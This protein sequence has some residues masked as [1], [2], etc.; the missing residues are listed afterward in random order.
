[1]ALMMSHHHAA[2]RQWPIVRSWEVKWK[3]TS[4]AAQQDAATAAAAAACSCQAPPHVAGHVFFP[5]TFQAVGGS[6]VGMGA[7][8]PSA[9]PASYAYGLL[10]VLA[11]AAYFSP[12][13]VWWV[14]HSGQSMPL[15]FHSRVIS[16]EAAR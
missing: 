6:M 8:W 12:R 14:W 2:A 1:M 13:D 16:S 7:L 10:G 9:W 3:C 5:A 11:V 15:K 4:L